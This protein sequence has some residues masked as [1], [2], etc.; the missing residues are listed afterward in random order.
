MS[1][2]RC[3][4]TPP[5]PPPQFWRTGLKQTQGAC[6]A[7]LGCCCPTSCSRSFMAPLPWGTHRHC[8]SWGRALHGAPGGDLFL[9]RLEGTKD[10]GA[11]TN[12]REQMQALKGSNV[13]ALPEGDSAHCLSSA[14][15]G[16]GGG[17]RTST[18][19][20]QGETSRLSSHLGPSM[21][22]LALESDTEPWL[23]R[24]LRPMLSCSWISCCI[25][26]PAPT[27]RLYFAPPG[28]V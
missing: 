23:P 9:R 2:Q 17:Q 8:G 19:G 28:T 18:T 6:V 14:L 25:R 4:A 1:P 3:N 15:R 26:S 20:S 7:L 13:V 21:E 11:M 22:G 10:L 16:E 12:C 27:F 5:P 24:A